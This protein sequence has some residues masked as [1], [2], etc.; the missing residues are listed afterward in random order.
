MQNVAIVMVLV[1]SASWA[2]QWCLC[3]F[4]TRSL[5]R[6]PREGAKPRLEVLADPPRIRVIMPLRGADPF[7]RSAV[8][9]VVENP[10]PRLELCVVLDRPDDPAEKIVRDSLAGVDPGRFRID[11]L[12]DHAPERS[13]VCSSVLQ[14]YGDRPGAYDLLT[15]CAADTIV[16]QKW[17][18]LLADAM[19]DPAVGSTLGNRWYQPVEG[20]WGSLVREAWNAGA[21]VVMWLCRIP[22]SGAAALRPDEVARSGLIDDWKRSLVEDVTIHDA[23]RRVGLR[24][25]FVPELTNVNAEEVDLRGGFRF[26]KRQMLWA[27][28][29]HPGWWFVLLHALSGGAAMILPMVASVVAVCRGDYASATILAAG[30]SAY[31]V[32]LVLLWLWLENSIRHVVDANVMTLKRTPRRLL[33]MLVAIPLTQLLY[34]AAVISCHV[35]RY[36]DWRGIRYDL[37]GRN[38]VK[39]VEYVPFEA[40]HHPADERTSI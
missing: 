29:Y 15:F 16:P 40:E 14:A 1:L 39:M 37:V 25:A 28:L 38:T 33:K 8:R 22:W 3:W 6:A 13:L 19:S 10:Y 26:I 32:G 31:L 30:F 35:A 5:R 17:F 23:M 7:L 34:P 27:R 36:V 9:S 4:Y 24:L 12:R 18:W 21:A 11:F 2:I 20:R